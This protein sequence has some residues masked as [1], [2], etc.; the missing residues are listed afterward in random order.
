MPHLDCQTLPYLLAV[1]HR[2]TA[3]T[4]PTFQLDWHQNESVQPAN[5]RRIPLRCLHVLPCNARVTMHQSSVN[6]LLKRTDC[7]AHSMGDP[8]QNNTLP[9]ALQY[10]I[11]VRE[12]LMT[13]NLL[14]MIEW[15]RRVGTRVEPSTVP[16][17]LRSDRRT[18]MWDTGTVPRN[19][20]RF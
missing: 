8:V 14:G 5:V 18:S 1:Q 13:L 7:L 6:S 12:D 10:D 11:R 19:G 20:V 2:A 3:S 17:P 15:S 9:Q 16:A 4:G